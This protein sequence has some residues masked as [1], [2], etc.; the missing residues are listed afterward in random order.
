[1]TLKRINDFTWWLNTTQSTLIEDR[2]LTVAKNVFYNNNR[3][4]QTRLWY[5][6][7]WDQIGSNPITS[8]FYFQKDDQ[9]RYAICFSWTA[10]YS[11]VE[12]TD[13]RQAITAP[14]LAQYETLDGMTTKRTRRDFTVYKNKLYMCNGVDL[15]S[16]RDWT[17][18]A[19]IW[20][21]S[22]VVCTFDHTTDTI[23]KVA[24]WLAVNDELYFV[25]WWTIP[26]W[27]VT[28]Q[29]YYVQAIPTAD[30]FKIATTPSA[31][32]VVNFTSNGTGTINYYKITEP[33]I[34][35]IAINQGVCWSS[36][37]DKNPTSLYYSN[38]LTGLSDLTNINT[39]VVVVWPSEDGIIN[40]INDYAQ[41]IVTFK[42]N[43]IYYSSLASWSYVSD[44][45]DSQSGGYGDR[46]TNRINNALVYFNE[47]WI[48]L[49]AKR[50]W[51]EGASA[52]ETQ[53]LS[54]KIRS[55]IDLIEPNSYNSWVWMYI[56]HLWN[57]YFS[58]D[59]NN[60]DLPDTTLVYSSNTWWWTY[61]TY[62]NFYDYGYYRTEDNKIK[63]LWFSASWWQAY[64]L[65]TWY[66]DDWNDIDFEI[67]TKSFDFWDPA[68]RKDFEYCD[69]TWYKQEWWVIDI[70]VIVDWDTT[71][72]S[73]VEDIH[74]NTD[75]S[76]SL[77]IGTLWTDMI[78][79]STDDSDSLQLYPYI[80]RIPMYTRWREISFNI[81]STNVQ[82]I[83]T[84][85][86]TNVNAETIDTF[87]FGNII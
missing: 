67:Q 30:T 11:Y 75:D 9:T 29:I 82:R 63:Y 76:Y 6:K 33:R 55:Y 21:S 5:T 85:I 14:T 62:P 20:L 51:V 58:F 36:W 47:R 74:L 87:T 40:G 79:A 8:Y 16:S 50:V 56:K 57:F 78:G 39:N 26:T 35:Y 15:Y 45:I 60:D 4:L 10:C 73:Q 66:T 68:Q 54:N 72:A 3:Q 81:S 42:N 1:M 69:F 2:D 38:P 28:Y 43:T 13:T 17:T 49:L 25:S 37:E 34:R 7:F 80:V 84:W 46:I 70:Q 61:Y 44:K 32:T 18:R 77:W 53:A 41:W 52:I 31:S 23:T 64:Q 19:S 27:I 83:L 86:R 22:S 59:T 71:I 48:D 12:G 65:E 24:H